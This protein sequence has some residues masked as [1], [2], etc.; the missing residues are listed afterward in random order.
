MHSSL[1]RVRSSLLRVRSVLLLF[2]LLPL[3]GCFAGTPVVEGTATLDGT[4][5]DNG[6]IMLQPL[7]GTSG[8]NVG[9]TITAGKIRLAG[10]TGPAVGKHRVEIRWVRKTGKMVPIPTNPHGPERMEEIGETVPEKYNTRSTLEIEVKPGVN[11]FDWK[12]TTEEPRT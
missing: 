7:P 2:C 6:A 8:A 12:L 1:L 9:G 10:P 4:P 3:A 11:Q 5:I